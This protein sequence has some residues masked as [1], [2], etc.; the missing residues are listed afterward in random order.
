MEITLQTLGVK[1]NITEYVHKP[2]N[3]QTDVNAFDSAFIEIKLIDKDQLGGI[4]LSKRIPRMSLVTIDEKQYYVIKANV[5]KKN[6]NEYSH[7]LDLIELAYITK[8]R[9]IPN[10][11]VT[12][13]VEQIKLLEV[14]EET[15][16]SGIFTLPYKISE[17]AQAEASYNITGPSNDFDIID[18]NEIKK[19]GNFIITGTVVL[20]SDVPSMVQGTIKL[21]EIWV[22]IRFG[23]Q[24]VYRG[25]IEEMGNNYNDNVKTLNVNVQASLSKNTTLNVHYGA[26][27]YSSVNDKTLE[28]SIDNLVIKYIAE[29][30]YFA[31]DVYLDDVVKKVLELNHNEITLDS[32]TEERLS[33]IL[34]FEEIFTDNTVHS[35]LDRIAR[36]VGAKISVSYTEHGKMLK[37]LFFDELSEQTWV[38]LI[39]PQEVASADVNEYASSLI[40][41]NSNI[42]KNNFI[43]ENLVLKT[44]GGVIQ[45]TTDNI[46]IQTTYPID[47]IKSV[48][49][50]NVNFKGIGTT[51]GGVDITHY[52]V[53]KEF[54]NTL[55][56]MA[57]YSNRT[58]DNKNN[59][60]WYERGTNTIEGL[61][62]VGGQF[63]TWATTTS[64][65]ALYET[66]AK[67]LQLTQTLIDKGIE[68]DNDI[69]FII[70]YYEMG[71]V[72][73]VIN[74]NDV[75]G[76]EERIQRKINANERVNNADLLGAFVRNKVNAIGNTRVA[77][78]GYGDAPLLGSVSNDN[79]RVTSV[80]TFKNNGTM[81]FV[82]TLVK[83]YI[84]ESEYVG[85]D[86]D[87]RLYIV[88][89]DNV[90]RRRDVRPF[91][92]NLSKD[93][94][95]PT[96]ENFD[97]NIGFILGHLENKKYDK[98]NYMLITVDEREFAIPFSVT[99][100][101]T[102][103]TMTADFL[104]N[105]NIGYKKI[106]T[107]VSDTPVAYQR[108]VN[109][110]DRF[111]IAEN[112]EIEITPDYTPNDYNK[113]PEKDNDN[114]EYFLLKENYRMLKDPRE[115]YSY[116]LQ[117]I[118]QSRHPDVIVY[119]G[120]A[121]F[122]QMVTHDQIR[123]AK[124]SY[125]PNN[126]DRYIDM[127]RAEIILINK[128]S[129][130]SDRIFIDDSVNNYAWY[131]DKTKELILV[132]LDGNEI[133]YNIDRPTGNLEQ[134]L[135][136]YV[137]FVIDHRV[138]YDIDIFG[139]MGDDYYINIHYATKYQIQLDAELSDDFYFEINHAKEYQISMTA[140]LSDDYN[141]E[142]N[143]VKEY[144][145]SSHGTKGSDYNFEINHAKEY[146][147]GIV[148]PEQ[149]ATP[150]ILN[151]FYEQ[152]GY[153][154]W[155][156]GIRLK[157][158][159]NVSAALEV[160]QQGL[161]MS[162]EGSFVSVGNY[163]AGETKV[164]VQIGTV[165]YNPASSMVDIIARAK[166][167]GKDMSETT[168]RL[169][170]IEEW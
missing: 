48:K 67:K 89:K 3:E 45:I 107:T 42:V 62:F 117:L 123:I 162:Y 28:I 29:E 133:F 14:L 113:L 140:T 2:I 166:A 81:M 60:L 76:F 145:I 138:K 79:Y 111:G 31:D 68:A 105:Y 5:E 32:A 10:I 108:G 165:N 51:Y 144:Q 100:I 124:I 18:N 57:N 21:H 4:D 159:D 169:I 63:E 136:A 83:D 13:P 16:V 20:T 69:R 24:V 121:K 64:N 126:D 134:S 65:R 7:K 151:I 148:T 39:H 168:Q 53:E 170:E 101:G 160:A 38:D 153:T 49:A 116:S 40:T 128:V 80:S 131:H 84:V 155:S 61:S 47:K 122:S 109:Y 157:N 23:S 55:D 114:Y 43:K 54:Y 135:D 143:H 115:A 74:K 132:L 93:P 50:Y 147:I 30:S 142:I 141:L 103:L 25:D 161:Y 70:E 19:D 149:T 112:V 87:R 91:E 1:H 127:T 90:V 66:L 146:E 34:A 8:L 118:G 156:I 130:L 163:N 167:N 15:E 71:E 96:F 46:V 37:F 75:S 44:K 94:I 73:A 59:H 56:N 129:I 6:N 99:P 119:D 106:L 88:P 85:I 52:I 58:Q 27:N 35:V 110:T 33:S 102:T 95:D 97:Y 120:F 86:S 26:R 12:Q 154:T 150:S 104:D 77:V 125:I 22:E 72:E 36:Y 164:W 9:A 139:G 152:V 41:K 78:Q 92:I 137:D 82:A 11:S 98:G 17:T 158:N